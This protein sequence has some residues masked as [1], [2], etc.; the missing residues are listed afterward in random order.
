MPSRRRKGSIVA[1][2]EARFSFVVFDWSQLAAHSAGRMAPE[3]QGMIPESTAKRYVIAEAQRSQ[4]R[5]P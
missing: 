1:S 4:R 5:I 3:S 2:K